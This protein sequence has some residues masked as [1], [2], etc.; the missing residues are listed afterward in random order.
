MVQRHLVNS[1]LAATLLILGAQPTVTVAQTSEAEPVEEVIVIGTRGGQRT[2]LDSPVPVDVIDVDD[3]QASGAVA[4]EL[5]QALAAVAPSFNFP[6]QSNSGTSDLVRAG[7]LR[8]LSPDQMLVLVNGK[9]RHTSAVVNSETK[10][11][12]GVAAVDF[13]NI[14]LNAIGRIEVLRDG[15]GA[16]YGSDAIA[17]VVNVVL[18]R[19]LGFSV[20]TG[21]GWHDTDLDPISQSLSDGE[22]LTLDA[23]YGWAVGDGFI[24]VGANLR[25]RNGTNRAGFDLIPF[26]EAQTPANLALQ[27]LRNYAE[28]DPDVEELNL[29][30]NAEIPLAENELYAFGTF[31]NRDSSG[32]GA[33]FRYPDGF[34]NVTAVYP[35]GYRPET[36]ADDQDLS[37][38][39]GL[40]GTIASWDWDGGLTYGRNKF[41]FGVDSSLNA[42][43]GT[44]SPTSFDS[45]S[46]E[47]K[48]LSLN[49]DAVRELTWS[50]P[51]TLAVGLEYRSEDY[52]T[53]QGDAASFAAGPLPLAIGAQAAPGLTPADEANVDRDVISVFADLGLDVTDALFVDAAARFEDYSDFGNSV[54]GKVSAR[55]E[56]SP[57]LAL[58]GAVSNSFRAPNL[59]HVGFAATTLNFG[60]N[61]ALIRTRTLPVADPIAQALGAQALDEE[62]SANISAGFTAQLDQFTL[63]IDVFRIQIDDRITLSE[64]LFGTAL[65]NFVQAQPGG[66][67]VE[68]VR[69]FT[70]AVDTETTGLD[71]VVTWRTE[72]GPGNL[73]L[74]AAYNRSSTD[75]ETIRATTP[76]LTALDPSLVL[77]GVEEI[78]TLQ[79]AA[80]ESKLIVSGNWTTD[81]WSALLR[82]SRF[83]SAVRVFNFGG[84][85]EPRQEYGAELQVD[86]EVGHWFSDNIRV[87]VGASNL[88]DEYPDL[89]TPV[90]NFFGNL[91][92]DILSPIGVNGRYVYARASFSY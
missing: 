51:A 50:M 17:G 39:V 63:A 28:G 78:N 31:G 19:S 42:S 36:R 54:T 84:G 4:A 45:G 66:T 34:S 35:T 10:I 22:T 73:K 80:P 69:F 49:L 55:Y 82:V 27:G 29:W 77:V 33:F 41:E 40:R 7:Q 90:I 9:R 37:L 43:L 64:R 8:G 38:A 32:G 21:Y 3:L 83:D 48:Q 81:R 53:R 58:R 2:A 14:P 91:P 87:F 79:D 57:G 15:A 6:R 60:A 1:L 88:L 30:F 24:K 72:L 13:N 68:S 89:S 26:F 5:G 62:T 56:I 23:D 70:N 71:V 61:Q 59:A 75:I 47:L 67:D 18:D 85:F 25:N 16:Q 52:Q 11:G 76:E 46:F 65:E 92:Y 20:N 44:A 12:R 74:S 86:A